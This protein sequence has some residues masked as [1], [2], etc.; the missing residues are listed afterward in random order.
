[1]EFGGGEV[2]GRHRVA[3]PEE[4]VRQV[5]A[6][7]LFVGGSRGGRGGGGGLVGGDSRVDLHVGVLDVDG[8]VAGHGATDQVHDP[9]A[10]ERAD[11]GDEG[12]EA[13]LRELVS[14]AG[15]S[16]RGA[17]FLGVDGRSLTT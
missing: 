13:E 10:Y 17:L 11:E 15:F 12:K 1:M 14:M 5:F 9:C 2:D 7:R 6:G 4:V 8:A 16:L 3:G